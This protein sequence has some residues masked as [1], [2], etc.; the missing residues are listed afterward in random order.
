MNLNSVYNKE[1]DYKPLSSPTKGGVQ[2]K[3]YSEKD[4][5]KFKQIIEEDPIIDLEALRKLSWQGVPP[6]N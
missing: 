3:T 1:E 5:A 4:I 6:G 2:A